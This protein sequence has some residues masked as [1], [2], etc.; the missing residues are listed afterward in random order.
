MFAKGAYP[1]VQNLL[2]LSFRDTRADASSPA[3]TGFTDL[4]IYRPG[5]GPDKQQLFTVS[6][7][8]SS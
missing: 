3:N 5:Y 1:K 6:A 4:T 7:T 8:A 2:V